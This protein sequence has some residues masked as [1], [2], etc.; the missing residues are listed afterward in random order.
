MNV[1]LEILG[2]A[3]RENLAADV[4]VIGEKTI[5]TSYIYLNG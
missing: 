2:M 3:I 4:R 1:D 5:I